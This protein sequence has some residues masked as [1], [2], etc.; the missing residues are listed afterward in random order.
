M[1]ARPPTLV[2]LRHTVLE[3]IIRAG[4]HHHVTGFDD[5]LV[6]RA[7]LAAHQDQVWPGIMYEVGQLRDSCQY[8]GRW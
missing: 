4:F 6:P 5:R 7:G 1:V 3:K 2:I 8:P